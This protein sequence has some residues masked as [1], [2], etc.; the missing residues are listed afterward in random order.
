M[1]QQVGKTATILLAKETVP[2]RDSVAKYTV[3]SIFVFI[4]NYSMVYNCS[5]ILGVASL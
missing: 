1:L 5:C 2:K 3:L 4:V